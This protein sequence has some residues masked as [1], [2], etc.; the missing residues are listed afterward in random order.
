MGSERQLLCQRDVLR[1]LS[2]THIYFKNKETT[3]EEITVWFKATDYTERK[4]PRR[5]TITL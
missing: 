2:H 3:A 4:D 5:S 1:S